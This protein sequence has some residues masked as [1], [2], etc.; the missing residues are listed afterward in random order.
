VKTT[1]GDG[2]AR[3]PQPETQPQVVGTQAAV[4]GKNCSGPKA[5]KNLLTSG[6]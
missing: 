3:A 4:Y 5:R 1:N 2:P 6:K